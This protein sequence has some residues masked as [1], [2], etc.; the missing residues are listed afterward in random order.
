M[1]E[2][3]LNIKMIILKIVIIVVNDTY[4][5]LSILYQNIKY[6]SSII[7]FNKSY[8]LHKI[9]YTYFNYFLGPLIY[10]FIIILMVINSFNNF[11]TSSLIFLIQHI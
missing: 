8:I 4:I 2:D 5:N 6:K 9:S 3:I 7:L 10:K 1:M 11:C